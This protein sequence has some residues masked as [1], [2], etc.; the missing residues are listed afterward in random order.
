MLPAR[1]SSQVVDMLIQMLPCPLMVVKETRVCCTRPLTA[2]PRL[3]SPALSL[4]TVSIA[5]YIVLVIYYIS[6]YFVCACHST[7]VEVKQQLALS[8]HHM[9]PGVELRSPS[10]VRSI[11]TC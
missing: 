6:L 3:L 8:F 9:G 1:L 10:L 7:H 2:R 11:F 5:Y 4:S